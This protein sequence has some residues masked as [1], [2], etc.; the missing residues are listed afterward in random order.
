MAD[1]LLYVVTNA[2]LAGAPLHVLSLASHFART[3]EVHCVVG[4]RGPLCDAMKAIGVEVT[5]IPTLRSAIDVRRDLA[6]LR[7]LIRLI[8]RFSPH[9]IHAHSSKAGFIA[10][11]AG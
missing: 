1:R 6:S 9:L 2:D 8:R 3:F 11:L 10:R 4:E 7:A 5:V